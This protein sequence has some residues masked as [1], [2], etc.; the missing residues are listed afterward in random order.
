MAIS[1]KFLE[2]LQEL[3]AKHAAEALAP[4]KQDQTEFGYG[5][6]VGVYQGI[7]HAEQRFSELLEAEEKKQ[8]G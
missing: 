6:S 4:S 2:A 5:K 8:R 3:K 7:L 1:E